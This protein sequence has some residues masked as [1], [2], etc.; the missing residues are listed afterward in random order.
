MAPIEEAT[1]KAQSP[2]Q[3]AVVE[4]ITLPS[5]SSSVPAGWLIWN[6]AFA[7]F[8]S[9]FL[10]FQVQPI[11]SKYI[12]P[13]FGGAPAVWTTCMLFFQAV[14]FCGYL[15][16]HLSQRF[17]TP[18]WQGALHLGLL[19]AAVMLLSIEPSER[20]KPRVSIAPMGRIRPLFRAVG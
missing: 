14:L 15:Y 6:F 9:A 16:A 8:T 18:K 20:W 1:V 19:L 11:I 4:P 10:L 17:L 12:L 2:V 3:A 13:C 5:V 7:I